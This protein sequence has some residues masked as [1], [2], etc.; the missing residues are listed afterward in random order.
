MT[1]KHVKPRR[2]WS[3][4]QEL[5]KLWHRARHA[6]EHN[7]R[8]KRGKTRSDQKRQAIRESSKDV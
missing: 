6:N 3:E 5:L 8:S 1:G 4:L 7:G 2:S